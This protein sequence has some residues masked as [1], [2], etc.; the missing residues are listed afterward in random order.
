MGGN[1]S[2]NGHCSKAAGTLTTTCDGQNNTCVVLT[3]CAA[4]AETP[5]CGACDACDACERTIL[6]RM[7]LW[8]DSA[9]RLGLTLV[10]CD[11]AGAQ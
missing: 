6:R 10:L 4:C 5:H 8:V 3:T 9:I 2:A 11:Q 1:Y 7:R